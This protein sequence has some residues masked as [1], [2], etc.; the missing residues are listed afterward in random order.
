MYFV[1]TENHLAG[2]FTKAIDEK[3]FNFLVAKHGISLIDRS[4][5]ATYRASV[6]LS[7]CMI[8]HLSVDFEMFRYE[9]VQVN[10]S[11]SSQRLCYTLRPLVD[12]S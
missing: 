11:H 6:I 10:P 5:A 9:K 7:F 12:F 8:T 3:R 4:S 2:L 1:N